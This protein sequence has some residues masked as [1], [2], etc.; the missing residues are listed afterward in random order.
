MSLD[1]I[2]FYTLTDAR[3]ARVA[4]GGRLPLSRC[5]ILLTGRCNFRCPY[6]RHVGGDDADYQRVMRTLGLWVDRDL[7]AVRFSGGEPTLWPGLTDVV[8]WAAKRIRHV[9]ISSNG[10]ASPDVYQ[11][12][13]DAG[14]NDFSISLDACCAADGERMSGGVNAWERVVENVRAISKQVYCT[15]GVVLTELNVSRIAEIVEFAD[16][17]GVAD[18]RVIPAAQTGA[19]LPAPK[20]HESILGRHPILRWRWDRLRRE[21][22]VRGLCAA[23]PHRCSLVLD[24]MAVMDGKHYPCIIYMREGGS[25][26]GGVGPNMMAHR[27]EWANSHDCH[28]DPICARNCLDFCVAHNNRV[29]RFSSITEPTP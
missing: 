17:L 18:I 11:R 15:V 6:C 1:V 12:L 3:A 8:E 14:A 25:P 23:D 10:S 9:A 27:L 22:P 16:S 29:R 21:M 13:I 19:T 24:D 20:L 4:R 28:Q 7:Q 2:G 26:I 5:E